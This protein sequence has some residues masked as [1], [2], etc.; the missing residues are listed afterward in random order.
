MAE[1]PPVLSKGLLQP[2]AQDRCHTPKWNPFLCH[3]TKLRPSKSS[4]KTGPSRQVGARAPV[5]RRP[6]LVAGR[7][8]WS[9]GAPFEPLKTG[10]GSA[11]CLEET[12]LGRRA[13]LLVAGRSFWLEVE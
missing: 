8:F 7:S 6:F 3:Q 12:L 1:P 5:L 2:L 10:G 11:T 13:L 9:Q 4:F